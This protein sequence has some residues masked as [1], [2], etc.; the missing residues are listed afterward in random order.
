[1]YED[2][3][4]YEFLESCLEDSWV[5]PMESDMLDWEP[6]PDEAFERSREL[7]LEERLKPPF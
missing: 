7:D 4:Y 1:M 5:D 6:D 3:D 2:Y